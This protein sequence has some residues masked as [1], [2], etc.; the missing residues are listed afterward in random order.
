MIS[1]ITPGVLNGHSGPVYSVAR[2][3]SE[4]SVFSGG[5][6]GYIVEWNIETLTQSGLVVR[7]PEAVFSVFHDENRRLILAGTGS[8]KI[9]V[10]DVDS[11]REIRC[12]DYHSKGVFGFYLVPYKEEIL[13]LGGDGMI[14]FWSYPSMEPIRQIRISHSKCRQAAVLPNTNS[15]IVGTSEGELVF[16][17]LETGEISDRFI[18]H[19][20]GLSSLTVHPNKPTLLTGG[21]DAHLHVRNLP[22]KNDLLLSLPAHNFA[23]YSI[24]FSPNGKYM[25][26]A[27][28]DKTVKIWD[29]GSLDLIQRLDQKSGGHNRSVNQLRWLN[30]R[31]FVSCGDDSKIIL[32]KLH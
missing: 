11:S 28:R 1:L 24:E 21:R 17:D 6:D 5:S 14:S 16:C 29:A 25:A 2:G 13:A 10:I 3:R 27:S 7:V 23:I 19:E 18:A 15:L 12:L 9:H 22:P 20:K 8:G 4:S 26:T 30:D 31:M 32:W